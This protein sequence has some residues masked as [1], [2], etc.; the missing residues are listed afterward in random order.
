[1]LAEGELTAFRLRQLIEFITVGSSPGKAMKKIASLILAFIVVCSAVPF[2]C[3]GQAV[4]TPRS[5]EARASS[6]STFDSVTD[7]LTGNNTP[8][9]YFL[10]WNNIEDGSDS[11]VLD[12]SILR[13]IQDYNIDCKTGIITFTKP[14]KAGSLVRISYRRKSGVSQANSAKASIPLKLDLAQSDRG[15]LSII[16]LYK[17]QS[18]GRSAQAPGFGIFGIAGS[19]KWSPSAESSTLFLTGTGSEGGDFWERSA[20]RIGTTAAAGKK[21]KLAASYLR[22]GEDFTGA[23]DYNLQKGMEIADL[24]IGIAASSNL[25]AESS[26]RRTQDIGGAGKGT[27]TLLAEHKM[28]YQPTKQATVAASHS[29]LQTSDPNGNVSS[30]T[31]DVLKIDSKLKNASASVLLEQKS[32]DSNTIDDTVT[33]RKVDLNLNPAK[34][35]NLE[36]SIADVTSEAK[37]N[38]K[39]ASLQVT[40]QPLNNVGVRLN[41]AL[42]ESDFLPDTQTHKVFIDTHPSKSMRISAGVGRHV[43]GVRTDEIREARIEYKPH[44]SAYL[45]GSYLSNESSAGN[46]S[47]AE[48]VAASKLFNILDLSGRYKIRGADS[49]KRSD[50]LAADL[51][52]KPGKRFSLIGKY[53]VNPEN[54]VGAVLAQ[55]MRSVGLKTDIG[56]ISISGAFNSCEDKYLQRLTS[57]REFGLSF[58]AFGRGLLSAVYK[59]SFTTAGSI[60]GT[61]TY[62]FGYVHNAGSDFNLTIGGSITQYEQDRRLLNDRTLY[63]A[64]AK[65]GL[66]F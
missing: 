31:L 35:V 59:E 1:M 55:D 3:S 30:A 61:K 14:L 41:Y 47:A 54:A 40:A 62:N 64:Q 12:G 48:I 32:I 28:R 15:G 13:K 53:A 2:P 50:T 51:V 26:I 27:E 8:G 25:S 24:S 65:L 6:L 18:N 49:G 43:L 33:T 5:I 16:G 9:P 10:S 56:A 11:V 20:F 37:G 58:G 36:A 7:I 4:S 39:S 17:Q 46:S 19:R 42:Q 45:S 52:L 21:L 23:S 22:S 29:S 63:E 34:M 44:A 38:D 57:G 66:R 60:F